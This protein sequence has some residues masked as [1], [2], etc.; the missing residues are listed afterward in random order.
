MNGTEGNERSCE[1]FAP[2]RA[3]TFWGLVA[4]TAREHPGRRVLEDDHGRSLTS[5]ELSAAAL[6]VASALA[7]RGVGPGS[8]V[9]WQLPTTL[10]AMVLMVALARLGAVQNPIIPVLRESELRFITSQ[11]GT[12]L[13]I[14][15][16]TWR[17]FAHG[18]LARELGAEIGFDVLIDV[19]AGAGQLPPEPAQDTHCRWI[20]YTSGTTADPKGARHTDRS[21]IAGSAGVVGMVGASSD[22]CNPLAFPISHI[23]GAAMLAASLRTGMR[24]ALFEGFDPVTSPSAIA[25]HHPTFLGSA[26]P[27]FMAF[28]EA[29]EAAGDKR[30]FPH[31]RACLAG[32]API[33]PELGKRV[34]KVLGIS[35]VAN[36]WGLTEFPVATS[37]RPDAA[38][39]ILD[40]TVGPPVPGVEVREIGG[41]LRLKGPQ[42]F[43]GYVDATLD[44]AAFDDEGWF[45][46]GD[47]GT[48]DPAGTVR[49]TGR[50]KDAIIRNAENISALEVE[51]V[52]VKHPA[53]ADVAVIGV[54]D[55]RAGERVCAFVVATGPVTLG[56]LVAH[57]ASA[58][59]SRYKHPERLVVVDALPRNPTGKVLK[60]DLRELVT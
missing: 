4:E 37:P 48:I 56:D 23:G 59:L 51:S 27:F 3:A 1:T 53:V 36:A 49:I 11:L 44:A 50:L 58:G 14:V 26:T 31:L 60:K 22:D 18:E 39:E 45:R 28:I 42:C 10:D 7:A 35:G 34:R 15:P 52:L 38:P 5:R 25:A 24:L 30:L 8:V 12:Q 43:L 46:T 29:Q 9:S 2:G 19:P 54:P 6:S 33:T 32:G 41:E 57:C 47:L 13:L 21:V 55:D 17:G 20:Y 40:H 16:E